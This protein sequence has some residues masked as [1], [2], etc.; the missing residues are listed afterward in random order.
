MS[1]P[2]GVTRHSHG[3][4]SGGNSASS[5]GSSL[6]HPRGGSSS[7]GMTSRQALHP[8]TLQSDTVVFQHAKLPSRQ[9]SSAASTASPRYARNGS[10]GSASG[11]TPLSNA[12]ASYS[13]AWS[14]SSAPGADAQRSTGYRDYREEHDDRMPSNGGSREFLSSRENPRHH[15]YD[16]TPRGGGGDRLGP[17]LNRRV[18]PSDSAPSRARDANRHGS[19]DTGSDSY[20]DDESVDDQEATSFTHLLQ[21]AVALTSPSSRASVRHDQQQQQQ[22]QILH[23]SESAHR[24]SVNTTS[25]AIPNPKQPGSSSVVRMT[26]RVMKEG[27]KLGFG[28]RH[29][30]HRKLRVS[31]LQGNSAAAKSPLRLG[32]ILLSVNGINLND[33]G[34]LEV[35]QHL[36]ATRPGELVFDI[37]RDVDASPNHSYEFADLD[38]GGDEYLGDPSFGS[39]PAGGRMATN[40]KT[41]GAPPSRQVSPHAAAVASSRSAAETS[42]VVV[43][44]TSTCEPQKK[45]AR[46]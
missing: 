41:S 5:A 16:S 44:T 20:M 31:T 43:A 23:D 37:E 11:S 10:R 33:L 42:S 30:S 15:H 46:P 45:R 34:F 18:S 26:I 14:T 17:T 28:I 36:K 40:S 6:H 29:D 25:S 8:P 9:V 32:D 27:N 38:A 2:H 1:S 35:I 39:T 4:G 22:Q 3:R 7:M 19:D 21:D 13:N 24:N 12:S